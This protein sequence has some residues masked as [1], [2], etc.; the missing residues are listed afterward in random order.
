M[1]PEGKIYE[2]FND[3][4]ITR[5]GRIYSH[6]S[7]RFLKGSE[8]SE[9]YRRIELRKGSKVRRFYIHRLVA[10]LYLE[11]KDS[12]LVINHKDGDKA[13]N[14]YTNLEWTTQSKNVLH[15]YETGLAWHHRGETMYNAILTEDAIVDIFEL[16]N[17]GW[18]YQSIA[19][20][21]GVSSS[22]VYHIHVNE[23]R[24]RHV[25]VKHGLVYEK[26]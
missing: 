11:K 25:K 21:C 4:I 13:N 14:H 8:H 20:K 1:I 2:D 22:C 23:N 18:T 3:Y 9:G 15:A 26:K 5:C 17:E 10:E 7:N 6:K 19:D 12:N 24:W 16:R